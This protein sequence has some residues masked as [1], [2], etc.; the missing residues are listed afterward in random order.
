MTR[1]YI[2]GKFVPRNPEKYQGDVTAI[3]ARSSWE[4]RLMIHLDTD[5]SILKW[6]SE[7]VIV[8]YFSKV[9]NK[10]H[11]YFVDFAVQY[12]TKSGEIKRSLVEVKPLAQTQPGSVLWGSRADT[13]G[14]I[15]L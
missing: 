6:T 15:R 1:N 5:P 3:F 9:D 4:R 14:A 11:R 13:L 10:W 8:P 7:T 2:Q 12:R